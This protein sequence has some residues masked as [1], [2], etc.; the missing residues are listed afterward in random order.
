MVQSVWNN[1]KVQQE[2]YPFSHLVIDDFLPSELLNRFLESLND[3]DRIFGHK[4]WGGKRISARFGTKEYD[5]F[6]ECNPAFK[7]IHDLLTSQKAIE[8]LY[9]WHSKAI[10]SSGLKE[11]YQDVSNIK[12]NANKTEFVVTS[13]NLKKIYI[14]LIYNPILRRFR[15]RRYFRAFFR[16]FKKPEIYPLI[17][18]SKS[19]GGYVEPLHTDSRHKVFVCLIY[20]DDVDEG[21]EI[22]LKKLKE[23][24]NLSSCDMYPEDK[25]IETTIPVKSKRNR[26]V[27][28]LN[29]N[30]AYHSTTPFEGLRRFIYFAYA[31]SN[32][33]SA[34][35]TD[36][37]VKLGDIGRD[38]KI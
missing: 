13:N 15:L 17:S 24:P 8:T 36:Q 27:M 28:F 34:F 2:N 1:Q 33:E 18:F 16:L 11:S 22:L 4:G 10:A 7:E 31:V 23:Q 30:N 29:Q 32:E 19:T 35:E 20:F 5:L 12:F 3:D 9:Q 37:E 38:Q 6:K 21:G 14:K 25:N 26:F